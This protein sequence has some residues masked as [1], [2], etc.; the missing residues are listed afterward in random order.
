MATIEADVRIGITTALLKRDSS[1]VPFAL[2][3][4][5]YEITSD[6]RQI[7][8]SEETTHDREE[9]EKWLNRSSTVD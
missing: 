7:V 4:R 5:T 3:I 8:I 2:V 9:I 6:E 1:G